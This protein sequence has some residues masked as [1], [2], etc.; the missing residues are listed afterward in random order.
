[1]SV[2]LFAIFGN[3]WQNIPNTLPTS[4]GI[5]SRDLLAFMLFWLVQFPVMFI[6][7]R[8]LRWVYVFKAVYT[9]ACLFGV[10]GWAVAMNGGSIG[11]ISGLGTKHLEGGDLV[12][13]MLQAINS[14][15]GV[16]SPVNINTGVG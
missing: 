13:P 16:S 4:A 3:S 11:N 8:R 5:T 14:V 12:W 15:L 2:M 10:L 1:M 7:P 9:P 6:H